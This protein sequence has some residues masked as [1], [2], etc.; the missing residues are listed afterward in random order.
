MLI[1]AAPSSPIAGV[2]SPSF[3]S[4]LA[5]SS[6]VRSPPVRPRSIQ[7]S[8]AASQCMDSP[9]A[10]RF[11]AQQSLYDV[12]GVAQQSD[13]K[14]IRSAYR[15]LARI[16]HPD[17]A[18]TENKEESTK[19]FLKIHAA[20]TTLCDPERRARYDLQLSLQSLPRFGSPRGFSG[21]GYDSYSFMAPSPMRASPSPSP[22]PS[23]Q[24]KTSRSWETDQ[25]W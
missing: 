16:T 10:T 8:A 1:V 19:E 25:C 20:Y 7:V 13:V 11:S 3:S 18:A 2:N 5:K 6:P 15:H 24:W 12:L 9:V 14:D 4:K 23:T 21:I 17:V 22:S